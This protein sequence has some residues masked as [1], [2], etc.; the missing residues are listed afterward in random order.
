MLIIRWP[1]RDANC[2]F[3]F[4]AIEL[5]KLVL[6]GLLADS[7]FCFLDRVFFYKCFS[8]YFFK[9]S[10]SFFRNSCL[11]TGNAR[12][13]FRLFKLCRYSAKALASSGFLMGMRKSSF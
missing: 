12:S 1:K 13:V 8:K 7:A 11:F 3:Y 9:Y 4:S 10:I 5:N 6:R 2:R